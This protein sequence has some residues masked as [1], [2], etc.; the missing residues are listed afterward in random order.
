MSSVFLLQKQPELAVKKM[1]ITILHKSD[2]A[3]L[4][5]CLKISKFQFILNTELLE[6]ILLYH[7]LKR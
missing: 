6:K 5:V 7:R 4:N 3:T 1:G 2:F